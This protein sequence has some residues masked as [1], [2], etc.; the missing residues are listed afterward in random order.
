[1]KAGNSDLIN[2]SNDALGLGFQIKEKPKAKKNDR[3][4]GE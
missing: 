1:M 3:I 2:V 4:K